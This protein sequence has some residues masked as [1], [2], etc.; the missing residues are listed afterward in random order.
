[1]IALRRLLVTGLVVCSSPV[2]SAQDAIALSAAGTR[3]AQLQPG[4]WTYDII[5]RVDA[6]EQKIGTRALLIEAVTVDG[7]PAWLIAESSWTSGATMTDSLYVERGSFRPLR[8]S[9]AL[10]GARLDAEFTADSALGSIRTASGASSFTAA[11]PTGSVIS[12]GMLEALIRLSPLDDRWHASAELLIIGSAGRTHAT[13]T[14]F[15]ITGSERVAVP[16]GSFETWTAT[17]TA[18]DGKTQRLWLSKSGG[19]VVRSVAPIAD[20]PGAIIETVLV[21]HATAPR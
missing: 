14:R 18:S 2:A 21:G 1:M 15:A 8:R 16:A 7:R 9:L 4:T 17:S 5:A 3:G 19:W 13:V 20:L 10:G 12:S 11:I 6:E